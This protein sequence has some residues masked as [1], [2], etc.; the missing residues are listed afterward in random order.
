M[1]NWLLVSS[2]IRILDVKAS[3]IFK[4]RFS[5]GK[6]CSVLYEYEGHGCRAKDRISSEFESRH[7]LVGQKVIKIRI[8]QNHKDRKNKLI[9]FWPSKSAL[10]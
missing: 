1:D 8:N 4:L 3:D 10:I 6:Y 7:Y 2:S 5:G 9:R